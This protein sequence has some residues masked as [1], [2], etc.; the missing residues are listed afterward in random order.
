MYHRRN[1]A[2]DARIIEEGTATDREMTQLMTKCNVLRHRID[3]WRE[4]QNVYMPSITKHL[5]Q[6]VSP[7]DK[8]RFF[9]RPE[10]IPLCLLSTLPSDLILTIPANFVEIEKCLRVSQADDSLNDLRR[11][12]RITI[13]CGI[14]NEMAPACT[15]PLALI[16]RKSTDVQVVTVLLAM[17][18]SSWTLVGCGLHA[19]KNWSLLTSDLL[20]MTW[21]RSQSQ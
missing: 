11:F 8:D 9:E 4:I 20:F 2:V 14:I 16:V 18:F 6:S 13:G 10:T 12:L 15:P 17:H 1:L 7:D 3:N 5:V 21:R 19:F